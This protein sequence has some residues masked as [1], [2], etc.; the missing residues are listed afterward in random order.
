MPFYTFIVT[1]GDAGPD[2]AATNLRECADAEAAKGDARQMLALA[3]VGVDCASVAIGCGEGTDIDWLGAYD[4]AD[5]DLLGLGLADVEQLAHPID[6]VLVEQGLA[7]LGVD[8]GGNGHGRA[9]PRGR[10]W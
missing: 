9:Q 3:R 7:D 1:R 2:G 4:W 8:L 6:P 10:R 5:G